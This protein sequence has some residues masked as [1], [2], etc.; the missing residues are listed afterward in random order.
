MGSIEM[1]VIYESPSDFPGKFVARRL[2]AVNSPSH[3]GWCIVDAEPF[4][5]RD[6]LASV[7]KAL[8]NG[9]IAIMRDLQDDPAIVEIW[10]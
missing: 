1:W 7:R 8:P 5:I 3:I 6:S 9:L 4:A 2:M 10:L